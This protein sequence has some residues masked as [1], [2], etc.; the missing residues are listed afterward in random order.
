MNKDT[1]EYT[2]SLREHRGLQ[3]VELGVV[4][5]DVGVKWPGYVDPYSILLKSLDHRPLDYWGDIIHG[6]R[7]SVFYPWSCSCGDAGCAGLWEGIYVK[8]RKYSVEWRI[9]KNTG[10][11]FLP[12]RF[13]SFQRTQY[14]KGLEDLKEKLYNLVYQYEDKVVVD[15]GYYEGD[16][17]TLNDFLKYVEEKSK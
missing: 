13:Y 6:A 16:E 5:N 11:D 2:V 10:Y 17:K 7:W 9:E 12:K 4:L 3:I 15:C 1:I 14:E 8:V